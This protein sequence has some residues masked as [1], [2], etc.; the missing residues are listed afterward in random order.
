MGPNL[1]KLLNV[2]RCPIPGD[3]AKNIVWSA[4]RARL[5]KR[6]QVDTSARPSSFAAKLSRSKIVAGRSILW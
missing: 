6:H 4:R 5:I 1:A 2:L 3:D